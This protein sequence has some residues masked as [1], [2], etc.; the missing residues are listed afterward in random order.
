[1]SIDLVITLKTTMHEERGSQPL[2]FVV[3]FDLNFPLLTFAEH[4]LLGGA[5][6]VR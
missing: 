1:V 3:T 2:F 5:F 6:C 4:S